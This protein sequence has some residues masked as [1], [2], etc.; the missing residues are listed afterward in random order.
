[1]KFHFVRELIAYAKVKLLKIDTSINPA[2]IGTKIVSNS[3]FK[4]WLDLLFIE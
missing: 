2:D 1:M 4:L 3:M